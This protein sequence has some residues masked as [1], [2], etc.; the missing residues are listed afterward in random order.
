MKGVHRLLQALLVNRHLNS[1]VGKVGV[2]DLVGGRGS[3]GVVL[4]VLVKLG[5]RTD[6]MYDVVRIQEYA[7]CKGIHIHHTDVSHKLSA[8][9]LELLNRQPCVCMKHKMDIPKKY[10]TRRV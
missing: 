5:D 7:D 6:A 8:E 1:D 4:R 3:G 2:D 10:R 9:E